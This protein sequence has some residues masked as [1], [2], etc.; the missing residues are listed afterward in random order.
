MKILNEVNAN[1]NAWAYAFHKVTRTNRTDGLFYGLIK[2]LCDSAY[3]EGY[4]RVKDD[5]NKRTT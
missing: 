5:S 2:Q 1:F 3:K 4:E